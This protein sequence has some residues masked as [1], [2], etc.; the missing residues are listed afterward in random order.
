MRAT[1]RPRHAFGAITTGEPVVVKNERTVGIDV[2]HHRLPRLPHAHT[3][4]H[5]DESAE[6][7]LDMD[8]RLRAADL[9]KRAPGRKG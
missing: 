1:I 4:F 5:A 2:Q 6:P 9:G 8:K 7:G 3:A